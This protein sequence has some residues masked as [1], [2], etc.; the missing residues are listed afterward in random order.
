MGLAVTGRHSQIGL[1]AVYAYRAYND[2]S[3][4]GV[5]QTAQQVIQNTSQFRVEADPTTYPGSQAAILKCGEPSFV[6]TTEQDRDDPDALIQL[7]Q[8]SEV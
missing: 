6:L 5:A 8:V 3:M 1:A 2:S 7:I 4:L